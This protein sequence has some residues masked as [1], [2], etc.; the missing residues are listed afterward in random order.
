[1]R[2]D[3]ADVE[4]TP[5]QQ[6]ALVPDFA[7]DDVT[8]KLFGGHRLASYDLPFVDIDSGL[9]AIEQADFADAITNDRSPEVDG[10]GGL[11]ALAIAYGFM[12]AELVGRPV[13]VSTLLKGEDSPY[14]NELLAAAR[15]S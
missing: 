4:I 6:L 13:N 2:R 15:P 1:L 5:E 11:R 9:L 8:A 3:G 14:Q 7:L 12:E 10:M